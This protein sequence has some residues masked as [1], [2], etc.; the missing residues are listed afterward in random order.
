MNV[1]E[2]AR[3]FNA[4]PSGTGYK[5]HCPAHEDRTESLAIGG[6]DDK[7]LLKCHAGCDTRDVVRRVG[8]TM[9]DLFAGN[10]NGHHKAVVI[11]T[12]LYRDLQGEVRYRKQR[13]ADKDFYFAQPDGRGGWIP[14]VKG[15][16]RLPYRLNEL[17][18][19]SCV[20][21]AEGEKDADRLWAMGLPATTNDG[22][23]GKWSDSLTQQ[24]TAIGVTLVA[25][26]PDND[27][28]GRAHMRAVAAS[29]TTAGMTA[30][31]VALPG[32]PEKGDISDY[33]DAGGT[34]AELLT[35]CDIAEPYVP[36]PAEEQAEPGPEPRIELP[37]SFVHGFPPKH[38]VATWIAHFGRQSDAALE[39][40]EAAAL[41]ALAQA[42][43]KLTALISGTSEGLRTNLYVLLVG[44]AGRSR[45]STAKDYGVNTIK[46]ALPGIL[47]P[48]Q[49]TQESLVESLTQCNG[50]PALWAIDEFTDTLV[51]MLNATYL[52]GMRG[53]LLELY[54]RTNYTYRRVSKKFKKNKDDEVERE[55]DVFSVS[56]VTLSLIGCATPTLFEDLD[57][58]AVGSGLLTRFAIVM[59][60]RKPPRKPQYALTE[61]PIPASLVR[62][63]HDVNLRT[64][65]QV[66]QFA[67]GVLERLD[68]AI[69]RPIDE[70]DD[71]CQM[72]VRM[73]AMGRKVAMLSAAG[74]PEFK[75]EGQP[76]VVTLEDAEAAIRVVSRWTDYARAFESRIGESAF[77]R[78]VQ[79]C[80]ALVKGKTVNRRVIAQRVHVSARDMAEIEKTLQMRGQIE[81]FE[82]R[83]ETGRPSFTW[84]WTA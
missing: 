62:W 1:A 11:A 20:Y 18:G 39:Y 78:N 66:V 8:L 2:V 24:L 23:A 4:K 59:P 15:I 5:A 76:L 46:Q 22:G 16:E 41:V 45:K 7:V 72:T 79:R 9:R 77:E 48:E 29:C 26:F 75:L 63:L 25:C 70:A 28:P 35:L 19:A 27:D 65:K 69:D 56:D 81:V 34:V 53:I 44:D 49:M 58:T 73:G 32:L 12:Y 57:S 13:T 60:E 68:D 50:G 3:R 36:R 30:S 14:N 52:A 43:P 21:I 54:G 74:R 83:P 82:H 6:N 80:V 71:R 33:F 47:L 84:R 61:D 55:E 17:R 51:K 67:P 42:T 40:H 10:G 38:F 64:A 37:Y 31:V